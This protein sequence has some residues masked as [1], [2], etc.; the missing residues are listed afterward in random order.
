[1]SV[2][3]DRAVN[4]P[5]ARREVA[6]VPSST[7][8][9]PEALPRS[10]GKYE[11][12]ERLGVGAMG[13]VYKCRQ[14]D[15]DRPVAVKVMLAA[16]H[17]GPDQVARFQREARAGSRLAHPNVVQIFDVGVDGELT[18]FVMEYVDGCSLDQL[19]GTEWLTLERTLRLV[20]QVA[21]ALQ[22]AHDHNI[23]HRDIKPSNILIDKAGRIKLADFGL[24][25]TLYDNQALSLSGDLIGTPRYMSPEQ[26]LEAH[27]EV[28]ARTDLYSLGAV[29]YEMLSGRAPVEGPNLLSILRQLTDDEP[30]PIRTWNSAVPEDVAGICRRAMAKDRTE[31]FATAGQFAQALHTSLVQRLVGR[32]LPVGTEP[33]TMLSLE[34]PCRMTGLRRR[35]SGRRWLAI[36]AAALVTAGLGVWGWI[37]SRAGGESDPAGTV[38][39]G[40]PSIEGPALDPRELVAQVQKQL[41]GTLEVPEG[42]TLRQRYKSILEDLTSVL[43]R[44]PRN[45][46]VR[47]LRARA[48]RRTGEHLAAIDDLDELVRRDPKNRAAIHERLLATYQLYVLY[49]G[50]IN[51]PLLRPR[52]F[53]R[54]KDDVDVLAKEGKEGDAVSRASARL[55]AALSRQEY[56]VAPQLAAAPPALRRDQVPDWCMLEC[57]AAFHAAGQAYAEELSAGDEQ[58]PDARRRRQELVHRSTQALRRGLDA[59]PSHVGLLFLR[60]NSFQR[61]ATW[62]AEEGDDHAAALNRQRLAF[63]RTFDRL[64]HVTLRVGCDTAIARAVLLSNFD[65]NDP[66]LDQ[67]TDA[68]SCRPTVSYLY[69]L[70]SWLRMQIPTEG[71]LSAEETDRILHEFQTVFESPPDEYNTYF[72]RALLYAAAGRWDDARRDLIQCRSAAGSDNLPTSNGDFQQWFNLARD[73]LSRYLNATITVLGYIPV[74]SDVRVRLSEEL[75]KRLGNPALMQQDNLPPEEVQSLKA[76]THVRLAQAYAEKEDRAR[77]LQNVREALALGVP[78]LTPDAMRGDGVLSSWNEDPEF[79]A[80]YVEFSPPAS[81]GATANGPAAGDPTTNEPVPADSSNNEAAAGGPHE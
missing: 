67:I 2:T 40:R 36:C 29:M 21:L 63:E 78:D 59:D 54:L 43:K 69:T 25:K 23:I 75:L 52:A 65:R 15:L 17:A 44:D 49:L 11:V 80:A 6:S 19:I 32:P 4:T 16:R 58:K 71:I 35:S 9:V 79:K 46:S 61:L 22:S 68:L 12:L 34:F 73:P 48:Y 70:K 20:Y 5:A 74:P 33:D 37:A 30:T 41:A 31:R 27:E 13:I 28:D 39:G 26:V 72:V 7:G 57:D 38:E 45:H 47:L 24:A 62:S 56:D 18:Y 60:A 50:N 53:E 81:E 77:V 55:A 42:S 1:M 10:I 51:E 14:P 3:R 66:A 64:R 8:A 76:W